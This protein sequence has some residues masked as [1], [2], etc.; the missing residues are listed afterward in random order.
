M[1]ARHRVRTRSPQK[2]QSSMEYVVVCTALALTLG[3][4]MW[5]DDSVLKELLQAFRTAYEKIAFALS[6]P[7]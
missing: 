5:S 3:I 6:L 7:G 2:G 4:G 1:S